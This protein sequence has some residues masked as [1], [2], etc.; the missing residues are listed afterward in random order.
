M[1][2]QR[3]KFAATTPVLTPEERSNRL[4]WVG[5]ALL[6][7]VVGMLRLRLAPAP[8]ERDEG[9]YAYAGQLLLQGTLPFVE[10]YNMKMPGIYAA[11][12]VAMA[13]FGQTATGIHVGL[14]AI[15]AVSV[16]LLFVIARRYFLPTSSLIA[17]TSFACLTL[18]SGALGAFAHATHFVALFALG[19][20]G[21]LLRPGQPVRWRHALGAGLLFGCAFMMKQHAAPFIVVAGIYLLWRLRGD[22]DRGLR[23]RAA[24]LA[25]FAA[26]V[27]A[28]FLATCL[29]MWE[30]G[31]FQTFWFWT[32]DYAGAYVSKNTLAR[33]PKNLGTTLAAMVPPTFMLCALALAGLSALWKRRGQAL[34][35]LGALVAGIVAVSPGFYYR[36]HYFVL[37]FPVA[38]VL[39]ALG[40]EWLADRFPDS[41]RRTAGPAL[42]LLLAGV[43]WA[44][45]VAA[46]RAYLFVQT[47]A[48]ISR[49]IYA[50]NPFPESIEIARYI[51]E[52][53]GPND[54]IAIIG[55]EPQLCFY[56]GRRSVS[57]FAYL[58]PLMEDQPFASQMQRQMIEQIENRGPRLVVLVMIT[59]SWNASQKSEPMFLNWAQ[60]YVN[61]RCE[62]VGLVDISMAGTAYYW[63][64]KQRGIGPRSKSW[65]GIYKPR[66]PAASPS[67]VPNIERDGTT[68]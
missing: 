39:A 66:D 7:V 26:G 56:S 60:R 63:D 4:A 50:T 28:P 18:N 15:N 22:A 34:F 62:R 37:L 38:A 51:R 5:L 33:I 23:E 61:E 21:V 3:K 10:V 57:G 52:H 43:A 9:E 65:V 64:D 35:I 41:F 30:A 13:L 48:E 1:S 29:L 58:Y 36:Q 59:T 53:T 46:D 47:P 54:R 19:G 55:S 45:Y 24:C 2:K 14:L 20:F 40:A 25:L 27:L 12:A 31:V 42:P 49:S 32:F 8:L 11:Y 17:A 6:I 16:V 67:P 44:Q 68:R